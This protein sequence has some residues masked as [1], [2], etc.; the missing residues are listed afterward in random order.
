MCALVNYAVECS[1][2]GWGIWPIQFG[3]M[4]C[5]YGKLCNSTYVPEESLV[6]VSKSLFFS[7][8]Y[9]L[10]LFRKK[11]TTPFKSINSLLDGSVF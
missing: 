3:S 1:S 10:T 2:L 11:N 8:R 4:A 9:C 7:Y 5:L 6:T